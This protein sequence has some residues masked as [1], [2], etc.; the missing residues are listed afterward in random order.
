MSGGQV[1]PRALKDGVETP[2]LAEKFTDG[3]PDGLGRGTGMKSDRVA[4][5]TLA[6][7]LSAN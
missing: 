4:S 2:L 7:E 3:E 5:A 6:A 1:K